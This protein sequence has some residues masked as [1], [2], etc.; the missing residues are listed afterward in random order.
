MIGLMARYGRRRFAVMAFPRRIE[1]ILFG[2]SKMSPKV[3][4]LKPMSSGIAIGSGG[5]FGAEGPIIMTGG[6]IGS[7][8]AQQLRHHRRG[9]QDAAGRGR[10]GRHDRRS[11]ARLWP[12]CMLAVELLLF[13]LRPRSL[14]PVAVACAV[15]GFT[16][17]AIS[18][19]RGRCSRCRP[20]P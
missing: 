6:A 18:L 2:K 1:A 15:A 11:S 12:P 3:A 20:R 17:A 7:L 14:L 10:G 8:I 9:A 13:E 5:P 19:R 4:L 16:R